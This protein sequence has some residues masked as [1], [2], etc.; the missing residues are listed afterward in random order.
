M[1]YFEWPTKPGEDTVGTSRPVTA[2]APQEPPEEAL[3]ET[4]P[5]ERSTFE[6]KDEPEEQ[7]KAG[8]SGKVFADS[9]GIPDAPPS[10][11]K[12]ER[13]KQWFLVKS[14]S[15][16]IRVCQ[17]WEATPKTIA[18]PFSTRDEATRAKP[19]EETT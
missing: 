9:A 7:T 18:G 6:A 15:G 16:Q 13:K 4:P 19:T 11:T 2:I 1:L 17:A 3:L 12:A 5:G 14:S 10:A 8:T